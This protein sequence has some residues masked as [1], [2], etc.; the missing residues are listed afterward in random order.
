MKR[1]LIYGGLLIAG[2]LLVAIGPVRADGLDTF[3]YTSQG[4]TLVWQLPAS[5]TPVYFN[6]A[7]DHFT[8]IATSFS[9]DGFK[10]NFPAVV[11]F[12]GS[13]NS[14]GF[15]FELGIFMLANTVGDPLFTGSL[16]LPTFVPGTYSLTDY[17]FSST[18]VPGSL[19]I[20]S[21][22]SVPEPSPLLLLACGLLGLMAITT[23]R[24]TFAQTH[25]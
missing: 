12:F 15:D 1:S 25:S 23:L 21:S 7:D 2:L 9:V 8:V 17:A 13:S 22:T 4:N 14:G 6:S 19:T 11:D 5:P 16:N 3:T 10:V 20:T 24:R 18:G